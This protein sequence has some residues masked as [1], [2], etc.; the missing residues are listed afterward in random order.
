[1]Y[2]LGR[3][4]SA[5]IFSFIGATHIDDLSLMSQM[6]YEAGHVYSADVHKKAEPLAVVIK[7]EAWSAL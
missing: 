5:E 6:L 2:I 4:T 7:T 3:I 1:M